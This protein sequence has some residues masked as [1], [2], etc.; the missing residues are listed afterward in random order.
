MAS[1]QVEIVSSSPFGCVLRGHNRKERCRESNVRAVQAV[2]EKNFK[3]L[4]RDHIQISSW[5]TNEQAD[6]IG[7]RKEEPSAITPIRQS[8]V[9]DRWVTR[10]AQEVTKHVNEADPLLSH[11]PTNS[12]TNASL[13]TSTT[14]SKTKNAQLEN[15]N[16]VKHNIGASSLVQMWEARLNR[17]NSINSNQNQ[18]QSTDPNTSTSRSCNE[19]NA[20]PV[21]VEGDSLLFD[22]KGTN[23]EDSIIDWETQSDRTAPSEPPPSSCSYSISRMSFDGG[24]KERVR[25]ADIIKRLANADDDD[26]THDHSQS[27]EHK[28]GVLLSDQ[29]EQRCFSQVVNSPRL[30]GRQAFNDLLIQME[31]NKNKELDSILERQPVSKF[32]QRGRLQVYFIFHRNAHI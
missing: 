12:N 29:S 23:H 2:F 28:H 32:S 18:S 15:A 14:N 16:S 3:E 20:S 7:N 4:V 25:I 19:N 24:E 27:R 21:A 1:S 26:V 8:P 6:N 17:S 11:S 5:V 31:Q 30:R 22:E 9:L 10:Q 13:P